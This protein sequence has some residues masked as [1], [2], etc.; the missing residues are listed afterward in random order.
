MKLPIDR[1]VIPGTILLGGVTAA[2]FLISPWLGAAGLLCLSL[3]GCFFR[4]PPRSEPDDP[5][6]LVS[7]ADGIITDITEVF[8]ERYLNQPAIRIGIFLSIFNCH[9][10]RT[11]WRGKIDYLKYVPG[12]FLNA[13]DQK[14]AKINESNWIG[15]E[16]SKKKVL[17][18]QISGAIARRIHFDGRLGDNVQR[19]QKIGIICYGSRVECYCPKAGFQHSAALGQHVRGGVT[20]LGRWYEA[21]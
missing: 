13:L 7:P 16:D 1:R 19:G 5:Q 10:T 4:D 21:S 9:V 20:V 18:R 11:P 8:E 6:S 2:A 17:F 3:H 14:S 12:M 15:L